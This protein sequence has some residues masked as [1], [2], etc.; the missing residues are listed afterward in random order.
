MVSGSAQEMF[1]VSTSTKS[2]IVGLFL[3]PTATVTSPNYMGIN[4]LSL[5]VFAENNYLYLAKEEYKFSRFFN[6]N[7]PFPTHGENDQ[8]AYDN[9]TATPK[10]AYINARVIG[11][12]FFISNGKMAGGFSSGFR[13]ITSVNDLPYDVAKFMYEGLGYTGL[14]DTMFTHDKPFSV[15]AAG[16]AEFTFNFAYIFH[17]RYTNQWSV[18]ANLKYLKGYGA[19]YLD[20]KNLNYQVS[21]V[22]TLIIDRLDATTGLSLPVDYQANTFTST[23]LFRGSGIG[24]DIGVTYE[25]K[26]D[27]QKAWHKSSLCK[28]QYVPPQWRVSVSLIDFGRIKFKK[29]ALYLVSDNVSTTWLNVNTMTYNS[30]DQLIAEV[31]N[32]FYGNPTELV[33]GD[34]IT[35][36]LPTAFTVQGEYSI[37]DHFSFGGAMIA[38]VKIFKPSL[39]RPWVIAA[40]PR[41]SRS[42]FEVSLPMSF[43][44]WYKLHVGASLQY[45]GFFVGSDNLAGFFSFTDFTGMN[46]YI[47]Y[48]LQFK[49]GSCRKIPVECGNRDYSDFH[50]SSRKLRP[51]NN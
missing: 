43:Y 9:F 28:V 38:P 47:G 25:S 24:L 51:K 16:F 33:Q 48:K 20:V 39:Q 35:I 42:D 14:Q 5:D 11:P 49:K 4:F 3:S 1:G 19:G 41:Y 30:I 6:P 17:Q 36:G 32:Q 34:E 37:T 40:I 46:F 45:R 22:D 2:D 10:Q 23:P 44:N 15:V 12:S 13:T 29:N 26:K 18:G 27:Y 7:N 31:S 50:K 21:S 8:V